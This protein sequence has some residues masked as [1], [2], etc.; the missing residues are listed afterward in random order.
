MQAAGGSLS[1]G[2]KKI[3]EKLLYQSTL[4][5]EE[6]RELKDSIKF[7]EINLSEIKDELE[8]KIKEN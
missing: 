3:S 2:L 8:A 4:T 6:N 1:G 7:T 5:T